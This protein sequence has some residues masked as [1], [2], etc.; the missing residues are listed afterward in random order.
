MEPFSYNIL[1]KYKDVD[2]NRDLPEVLRKFA[3]NLSFKPKPYNSKHKSKSSWKKISRPMKSWIIDKTGMSAEDKLYSQIISIL[4]KLSNS[5]FKELTADFEKLEIKT[6]EHLKKSI[7]LIFKKAVMESKYNEIYAK[8]CH[9]LSPYFIEIKHVSNAVVVKIVEDVVEDGDGD[10][11]EDGDGDGD[12]DEYEDEYEYEDE[13]V[14]ENVDVNV[15]EDVDVDVDVD[16]DVLEHDT[17]STIKVY[18]RE[19]L[20]N[21]CQYMFEKGVSF[22]TELENGDID[23]TQSIFKFKDHVLGCTRFIGELYNVGLL[24]DKIIYSC[25]LILFAKVNEKK[26][27]SIDC[28]C[29]L[30]ETVGKKF[31]LSATIEVNMLFKKLHGVKDSRKVNKRDKFALM[32]LIDMRRI[33]RWKN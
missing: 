5:N 16:E 2:M 18:F 27:Y 25:F 13:D 28:I 6:E 24:T 22:E 26:A 3:S 15:D 19:L 7:D 8:L 21:K 30:M 32:D 20:L 10:G 1:I 14:D 9:E 23:T 11:V 31:S 17:V 4:N 12:E 33:R 29:T